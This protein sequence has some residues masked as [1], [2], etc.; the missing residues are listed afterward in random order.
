MLHKLR[1]VMGRRD[2][3]YELSGVIE[4]DEGFFTTIRKDEE[5]ANPL[6]R[7]RGS[8]KKSKVLVMVES[9]PIEGKTTKRGK[10][11]KVGHLK[12]IVIDDLK[13]KTITK[14]VKEKVS[15]NAIIDSD[16]ST[17]YVN[18]KDVVKEHKPKVIPKDKVSEMLP[19]VHL[20]ISNAK[21]L[22]LDIHHDVKPEYLQGYLNEFC[23]KYNRRYFG[24]KMLHRLLIA[25]VSYKN[26]W[27]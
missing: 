10:P 9:V 14:K 22:L 12:M 2:G 26:D 17:S 24:E 1:E 4:L 23:Y 11:R 13:A 15:K 20:A 21:R 6:K 27:V 3:E 25:C 18:L 19:W 7:G 5:K 8:Q 16:S